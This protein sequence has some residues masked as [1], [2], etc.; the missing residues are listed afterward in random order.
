M[1]FNYPADW[2]IETKND[3]YPYVKITSPNLGI[4]QFQL[5]PS[6]QGM[7][8]VEEVSKE[9]VLLGELKVD[10]IVQKEITEGDICSG[11]PEDPYMFIIIAASRND[12][13]Y[14]IVARWKSQTESNFEEYF[15]K[16]IASFKFLD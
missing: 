4:I 6:T 8:C 10:K 2:A 1:A 16:V 7:E 15:D 13:Y 11:N 5:N 12:D 14:L 3:I 9:K